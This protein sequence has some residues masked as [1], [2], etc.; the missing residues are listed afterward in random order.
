MPQSFSA[1]SVYAVV[2]YR[3]NVVEG[4]VK[5]IKEENIPEINEN[6]LELVGVKKDIGYLSEKV[7][8]NYYIQQQILTEVKEL[9][10]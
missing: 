3:L 2:N 9:Q 4:D 5:H 7:D 6:K 1:G 10:R 8:R